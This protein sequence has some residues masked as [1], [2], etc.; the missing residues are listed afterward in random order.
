[1]PCWSAAWEESSRDTAERNPTRQS[2]LDCS[3]CAARGH[4]TTEPTRVRMN[5]R[6]WIWIAMRPSHGGHAHATEG[7]IARFNWAVCGYFTV[8]GASTVQGSGHDRAT[9]QP[10]ALA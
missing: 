9:A 8:R 5:S 10:Q 6:R 3:A 7:T 1:M 2:L 4:A